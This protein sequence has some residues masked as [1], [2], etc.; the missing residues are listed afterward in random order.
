MVVQGKRGGLKDTLPDDML[1]TV[2][3]ATLQRTGINPAV[4]VQPAVTCTC[5]V[6]PSNCCV[7]LAGHRTTAALKHSVSRYAEIVQP[8]QKSS[9]SAGYC[10]RCDGQHAGRQNFMSTYG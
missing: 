9:Y 7:F 8:A 2:I 5:P 1:A 10:R 3:A 4:C 6:S